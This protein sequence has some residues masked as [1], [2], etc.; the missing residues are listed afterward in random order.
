MLFVMNA[1]AQASVASISGPKL[2]NR[3]VLAAL[4]DLGIV[5]AGSLVILFAADALTGDSGAIRGAL[6]GVI[7]GWA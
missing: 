7:L 5:L 4:V 1:T 3:R 6:G 2:D